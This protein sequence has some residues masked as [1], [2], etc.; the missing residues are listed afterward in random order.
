MCGSPYESEYDLSDGNIPQVHIIR[1]IREGTRVLDVGCAAGR[2]AR[3]L[4]GK[5]CSVIGVER[6]PDLAGRARPH[7]TEVI[8]GDVEDPR[9]LSQITG[10]FDYVILGDILEHLVRSENLLAA[11]R[12]KLCKNGRMMAAIPNVLVWHTR[13]E[14][15][16]GRFDYQ[17]SGTLDRTHLRFFTFKT[18]RQLI[19]ASGY[20]IVD[21]FVSYHVPGINR[22][23]RL[24]RALFVSMGWASP[25]ATIQ[26]LPHAIA[27]LL[28]GLF[29]N[30]FVLEAIPADPGCI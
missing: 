28:P 22:A 6:D 30:H 16:L 13:K 7:C 21:V 18:A 24:M 25:P 1:R 4:Q 8:L 2:V 9:V 23:V 14:F 19:E 5:G 10:L 15:L 26:A 11:L 3:H 12:T 17:D 27:R 20:R 29:G